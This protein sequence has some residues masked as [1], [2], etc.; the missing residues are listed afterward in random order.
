MWLT[1]LSLRRPVTL[2]MAIASVVVLGAVS[3]FKLPLD[4][5]PRVEF[6]FI[7]VY[8]PYQGGIPAENE[9][10]IVRPLEEVLATLGGV[11]EISSFSDAGEVQVGVTF[12]WGRDVNLLRLE[13]KEKIDQIRDR[14]PADIPQIFLLTFNT[15]DIPVIE[16]RISARG[17]D[18]S[19]SWDLIDQKI[20]G[21]LQRIPG[22]GRVN[23]DGV[24]PTQASVY[25]R[26]DKIREHQVDLDQL[27][28]LSLIHI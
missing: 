4:F 11:K 21:P 1:R 26:L 27:F 12:D 18:L 15:S 23:I 20:I 6:P 17:R 10:E 9:R 7:A 25:L 16:G 2:A 19:E 28:R 22:V 3:V 8:V 5:L 14:L 24:L 13:V